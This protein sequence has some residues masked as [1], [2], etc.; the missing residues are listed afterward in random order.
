MFFNT[1]NKETFF[2]KAI[3]LI[4]GTG[5]AQILPI[6]ASPILTRLFVPSEFGEMA[7]FMATSAI[8]TIIATG[9]F[10]LA[11]MLPKNDDEALIILVSLTVISFL[12]CSIFFFVIHIFSD[13]ILSFL[14]TAFTL[15]V[16]Y[17]LPIG[18]FLS[19]CSQGVSYWLNRTNDF[20]ALS[21]YRILQSAIT[22]L[23]GVFFGKL[24][25]NK[26]GLIFSYLIGLSISLGQLFFV[27]YHLK[28]KSFFSFFR[29]LKKYLDHPKFLM[30]SALL[31]NAAVQAPVFFIT[32]IF[33]K[34]I[35]GA[36]SLAFRMVA[37][38]LSIISST[39][40][41]VYF[42]K[43]SNLAQNQPESLYRVVIDTSKLLS[44]FSV[45]IFIPLL[46]FGEEIF[47]LV[48]GE[49]WVV[50]GKLCEILS[51]AMMMKFIVSPLST[52][53]I[54]VKKTKFAIMW[55]ILYFITTISLFILCKDMGIKYMMIVYVIHEIVLYFIYYA[56]IIYASKKFVN[57]YICAE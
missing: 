57:Q 8:F 26:H 52:M 48:F 54:I 16:L 19:G 30:P 13:L 38:P 22:V 37:S 14:N 49:S 7:F 25:Y 12:F 29:V 4:T 23:L 51:V 34:S 50:A 24:G 36:Y 41:Q 39:I 32:K 35:V 5:I 1:T 53:F 42:N 2:A 27:T 3:T 44:V 45:I 20:N 10:E 21:K 33:S 11:I 15:E 28:D 47:R 56:L 55:Q 46:T 40:G 6:L 43:I 9:R 17:L 18:I 31:D